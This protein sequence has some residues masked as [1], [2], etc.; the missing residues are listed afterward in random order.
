VIARKRNLEGVAKMA[1]VRDW[2][3]KLRVGMLSDGFGLSPLAESVKLQERLQR[4]V[5]FEQFQKKVNY[6]LVAHLSASKLP[7]NQ[8]EDS[9]STKPSSEGPLSRNVLRW[10]YEM[11]LPIRVDR[12]IYATAREIVKGRAWNKQISRHEQLLT[13]L[14]QFPQYD[15][16]PTLRKALGN[17]EPL[18][19]NRAVRVLSRQLEE[20][21]KTCRA[22]K[23]EADAGTL[24][25]AYKR[26]LASLER[27]LAQRH[28]DVL[29]T[30]QL[31]VEVIA[32]AL[33]AIG[34]D[35]ADAENILRNL[36][37]SRLKPR[38]V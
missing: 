8:L 35:I 11:C 29:V 28:K 21:R 10:L 32:F 38:K 37:P 4:E 17:T 34:L 13:L 15:L 27:R 22:W 3:E 26:L 20:Q 16:E 19:L 33:D 6:Q 5:D 12:E 31:R 30:K 9:P 23:E 14:R 7:N 2:Q 24:R 25:P 36:R 1:K 18:R